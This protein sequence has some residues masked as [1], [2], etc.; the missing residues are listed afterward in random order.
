MPAPIPDAVAEWFAQRGWAPFEYQRHAWEAYLTGSAPGGLIH[1]P[2]GVG[3][4]VLAELVAC[5]SLLQIR[6]VSLR[7]L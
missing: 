2:T 4:N 6:V 7:A 3:K 1:A 5:W